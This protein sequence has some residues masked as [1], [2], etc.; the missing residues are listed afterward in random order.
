MGRELWDILLI[1]RVLS[2][3]GMKQWWLRIP[4]ILVTLLNRFSNNLKFD[5]TSSF[6]T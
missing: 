5:A 2:P 1:L 6:D 3:L 4:E